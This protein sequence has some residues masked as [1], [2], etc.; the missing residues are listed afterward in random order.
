MGRTVSLTALVRVAETGE[1]TTIAA[2]ADQGRITW[3]AVPGFDT[4][5]GGTR[6][7]YFADV[8]ENSGW[9]ISKVAYQS[10]TGQKVD[11]T[12][13]G[14]GREGRRILTNLRKGTH[15]LQVGSSGKGSLIR[16][17]IDYRGFSVQDVSAK[18]IAHL[19]DRGYIEL[20]G[21]RDPQVARLTERGRAVADEGR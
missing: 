10:R 7:A 15:R 20:T 8:A 11:L 3:R 2:L 1:V 13:D 5:G 17:G 21:A 4:R 18:T 14:P 12:P 19:V 6:T 16:I 9:E